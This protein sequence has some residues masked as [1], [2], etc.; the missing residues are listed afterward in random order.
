MIRYVVSNL[1]PQTSQA[2]QDK[3]V[4]AL[5]KVKGLKDVALNL[6]RREITFSINGPEPKPRLLEEACTSAGFTLG[7]RM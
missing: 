4:A 7:N 6:S 1:G 2:D 5:G 3:L